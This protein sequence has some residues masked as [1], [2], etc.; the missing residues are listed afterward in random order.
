[1]ID[2]PNLLTIHDN[3]LA[4]QIIYTPY[5][6][7]FG[8][9]SLFFELKRLQTDKCKENIIFSLLKI[10]GSFIYIIYK[11]IYVCESHCKVR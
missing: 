10:T 6:E 8:M 3:F 4:L 9:P 5:R 7:K 1:M 2:N 11:C